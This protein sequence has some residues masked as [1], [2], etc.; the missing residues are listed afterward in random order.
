L[1]FF[2]SFS[3]G[4]NILPLWGFG[5]YA[6]FLFSL[7]LAAGVFFQVPLLLLALLLLGIVSLDSVVRL[8]PWMILLIGLAAALLTPPDVVSQVLLGVPMYLL[9]ELTLFA[10][11]LL[12]RRRRDGSG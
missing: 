1:R 9:F 7:L 11:R 8:R 4:D 5:E 6:S 2:L 3:E 12:L 10:A